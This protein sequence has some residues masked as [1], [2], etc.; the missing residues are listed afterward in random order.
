[1]QTI[2]PTAR[3]SLKTIEKIGKIIR[4]VFVFCK[5]MAECLIEANS[6]LDFQ[7][8][9]Y[10][11]KTVLIQVTLKVLLHRFSRNQEKSLTEVDHA[12]EVRLYNAIHIETSGLLTS[13]NF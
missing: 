9:K 4:V 7:Q 3:I 11:C 10:Y 5:S 12:Y 6:D 2:V 1:M 13:K 8:C